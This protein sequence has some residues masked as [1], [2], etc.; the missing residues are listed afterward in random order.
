MNVENMEPVKISEIL[1][2]SPDGAKYTINIL[3]HYNTFGDDEY[4]VV[5]PARK[6]FRT[7]EGFAVN[8]IDN[9]RFFIQGPD[10]QVKRI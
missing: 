7:C 2:Q 9:N 5:L 4:T 10:V 6:E 1:V 8:R 3:Q